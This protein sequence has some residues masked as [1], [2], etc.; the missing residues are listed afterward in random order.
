MMFADVGYLIDKA[1]ESASLCADFLV[2]LRYLCDAL[3][4]CKSSDQA[5]PLIL[6]GTLIMLHGAPPSV[7]VSAEFH[8]IVWSVFR[9]SSQCQC[10]CQS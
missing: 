1:A 6:E 5:E 4:A 10:Q 2:I 7:T 8:D 9:S 3:T